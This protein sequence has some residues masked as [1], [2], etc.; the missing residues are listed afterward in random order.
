M[1]DLKGEQHRIN[2]QIRK[3]H[4]L[5]TMLK[6]GRF[7]NNS[8]AL[9]CELT[10]IVGTCRPVTPSCYIH[11]RSLSGMLLIIHHNF[12]EFYHS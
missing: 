12:F 7:I 2:E 10:G 11:E 6:I 5:A 8:E 9:K 1:T 4:A 3:V